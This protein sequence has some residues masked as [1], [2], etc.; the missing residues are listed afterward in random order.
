MLANTFFEY[1]NRKVSE[2]QYYFSNNLKLM[3]QSK[4]E[5]IFNLL[6]N[7]NNDIFLNPMLFAFL[8]ADK[9]KINLEQ[10]LYGSIALHKRPAE[11]VVLSNKNGEVYLSGYGN[12]KLNV[13]RETHLRLITNNKTKKVE[14]YNNHTIIPHRV[15]E[16]PTILDTEIEIQYI[17]SCF[18]E[19]YIPSNNT[20]S[21]KAL[22]SASSKIN[23]DLNKAVDILKQYYPNFYTLFCMVTKWII[24]FSNSTSNSFAT[25]GM[26]GVGFI[27]TYKNTG[28][29]FYLEDLVHQCGHII[30]SSL[31]YKPK[32]YF[33][34]NP[35]MLIKEFINDKNDDRS[36]YILFHGVFTEGLMCEVFDICIKNKVFNSQREHELK[37]RFSYILLRF[38]LDM[39]L[40]RANNY[41]STEGLII[42]NELYENMLDKYKRYS[43]LLKTY[44]LTNQPYNFDYNKFILKNK[45]II[46]TTILI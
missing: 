10:I 31:T 18:T 44:D 23:N 25:L 4:N 24:P 11:I 29:V 6:D 3:V 36:L 9:S 5:T 14:V 13:L 15:K 40:L 26:H 27:N 12:I 37:G 35:E 43:Y 20:N 34:I 16:N 46:E 1:A 30:F 38:I 41:F 7:C 45:I 8:N 22:Y 39:E 28:I 2:G 17:R 19:K 32:D 42:Y 21:S 33:T